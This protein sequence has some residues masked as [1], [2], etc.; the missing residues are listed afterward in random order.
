MVINNYSVIY[1][2]Q[3]DV[4][5]NKIEIDVSPVSAVSTHGVVMCHIR[6][7]SILP[8]NGGEMSTSRTGR[9]TLGRLHHWYPLNRSL[10]GSQSFCGQC[11]EKRFFFFLP[12]MEER[13]LG[14]NVR[15]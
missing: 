5:D 4:Y 6:P 3:R 10:A 7:L 8:L 1:T 9:C 12:G 14:Y 13:F 11:E 15:T 2:R